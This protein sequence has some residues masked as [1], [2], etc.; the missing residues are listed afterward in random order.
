MFERWPSRA[1]DVVGRCVSY[2][3]GI[4]NREVAKRDQLSCHDEQRYRLWYLPLHS[5]TEHVPTIPHE[6]TFRVLH[7]CSMMTKMDLHMILFDPRSPS[8]GMISLASYICFLGCDHFP[9]FR[10]WSQIDVHEHISCPRWMCFVGEFHRQSSP[11]WCEEVQKA[12][13]AP[14]QHP[15]CV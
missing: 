7:L 6:C 9:F 14:F 8:F 2:M 13:L 11:A 10:F 12:G 5:T 1:A 4:A 15:R 3:L